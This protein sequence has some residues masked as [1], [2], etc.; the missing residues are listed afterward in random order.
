[1]EAYL[2]FPIFLSGITE[3][4]ELSGGDF[5]QAPDLY[6]RKVFCL[7]T[8]HNFRRQRNFQAIPAPPSEF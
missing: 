6:Y 4:F 3:D 1:M 5:I 7:H 2:N 8:I